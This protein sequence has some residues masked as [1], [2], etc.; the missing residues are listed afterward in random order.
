M[1]PRRFS[2]SILER[3]ALT[4]VA[5]LFIGTTWAFGG[6]A[7]WVRPYIAFGG[8][9]GAAITLA[10]GLATERGQAERLRWRVLWPFIAFNAV[11]LVAILTP[12]FRPIRIDGSLGYLPEFVPAWRPSAAIPHRVVPALTLFDGLYLSAFNVYL[13]L[14]SR[15]GLRALLLVLLGNSVALAAFGTV[16]KLVHAR[17]LFFGLVHSPQSYFFSTFVYDNHWGAFSILLSGVGLGLAWHYARRA[18]GWEFLHTPGFGALVGMLVIAAS[19]PLSGARVCTV[20]EGILAAAAFGRW[21]IRTRR[22]DDRA[23]ARRSLWLGVA[24]AVCALAAIWYV[25]QD[26]IP[27]RVTKARQ[28][29]NAMIAERNIG[30]RSELYRDTWRMAEARPWFGWGMD[31]YPLVFPIYN[32]Q[33]PD[34]RDLLPKVYH[35]AHTDWLQALAEHGFVGT[36]LLVLCAAL[37]LA[38]VGRSPW[39]ELSRQLLVGEGLVLL[40]AAVEFPFGNTAVVLTWWILLFVAAR[41]AALSAPSAG[42]S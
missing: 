32:R 10:A 21:L 20:L 25:G 9:V 22:D 13:L 39:P 12:G 3:A 36:L 8:A 35:D 30:N 28:Q 15:R 37:P 40:Y 34:P 42:R 11:T 33:G 24:A 23:A 17:G 29:I 26:V 31:S 27:G 6:N 4:Q 14:D 16:Q 2:L 18:S 19:V 5:L 38:A 7:V 1:R 41:Y